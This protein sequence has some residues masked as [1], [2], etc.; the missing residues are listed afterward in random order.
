MGS[1]ASLVILTAL[2]TSLAMAALSLASAVAPALLSALV[3]VC[4]RRSG[5]FLLLRDW[6]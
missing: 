1:S 3:A 6:R 4:V 2:A 5:E